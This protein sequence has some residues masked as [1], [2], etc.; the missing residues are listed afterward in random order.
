MGK[1]LTRVLVCYGSWLFNK[2]N[3]KSNIVLYFFAVP[4]YGYHSKQI[5]K[6]LSTFAVIYQTDLRLL[7]L[8]DHVLDAEH[9]LIVD[10][11]SLD[12]CLNFAI[13][14]LKETAIPPQYLMPCVCGQTLENI[15]TIDNWNVVL[16]HVAYDKGTRHIDGSYVDLWLWP[17]SDS[18]Q[19]SK[20]IKAT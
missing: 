12:A 10:I 4:C 20:H 7:S 3:L 16:S 2:V 19:N 18:H 8:F 11:L 1:Q 5:H 14:R 6:W 13:W 9:G 15:G 17:C